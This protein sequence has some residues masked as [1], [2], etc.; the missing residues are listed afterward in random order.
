MG[1][2]RELLGMVWNGEELWGIVGNREA[3]NGEDLLGNAG[4]GRNRQ[5]QK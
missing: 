1:N 5:F 4:N 2:N 3:E